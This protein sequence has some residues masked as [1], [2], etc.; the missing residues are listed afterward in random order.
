MS[1]KV[2]IAILGTVIVLGG[3]VWLYQTNS[4][5][6]ERATNT[7]NEERKSIAKSF[8]EILSGGDSLKCDFSGTDPDTKELVKGTIYINGDSFRMEADTVLEG[9]TTAVNVINH[10]MVMYMW[11]DDEEA[12][13]GIMIDTRAFADA[14]GYEKPSSPIDILK[15]PESNITHDCD[16]WSPRDDSFVPPAEIE[17]TDMFGE[18]GKAFGTMMQQGVGAEGEVWAE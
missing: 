14:E 2:I 4:G 12:M 15:D 10:N 3:G 9:K 8:A 13:P 11:S 7:T 1:Q 17:F 18:L 6:G 16:R 5:E